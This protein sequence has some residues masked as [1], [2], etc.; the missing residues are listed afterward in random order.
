MDLEL[1]RPLMTVIMFSVFVCIV[2]WAWQGKQRSRFEAAARLP[3][4][5]DE[6]SSRQAG[7][8]PGGSGR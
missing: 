1:L 6:N 3:F 5:D 2:M 8:G 4:D 7:R